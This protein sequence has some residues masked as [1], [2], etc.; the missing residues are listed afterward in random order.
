MKILRF[1]FLLLAL[2]G[3][4]VPA[5]AIANDR[6]E[7]DDDGYD[8]EGDHERARQA[9]EQG[10]IRPLGELLQIVTSTIPGEIVDVEFEKE[11]GVWVYEFYLIDRDGTLLEVFVDAKT[12]DIMKIEGE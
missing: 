11:D 5:G 8:Y 7:H 10:E 1:W 3:A 6:D 4:V 12:G 9:F 2:F